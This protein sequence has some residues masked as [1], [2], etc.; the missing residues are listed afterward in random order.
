VNSH[1]IICGGPDAN[2]EATRAIISAL[3]AQL[4]KGDVALP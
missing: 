4:T 2:A 1:E 3:K